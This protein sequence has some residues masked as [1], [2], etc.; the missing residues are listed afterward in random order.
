MKYE[1]NK[2]NREKDGNREQ[3]EKEIKEII[4]DILYVSI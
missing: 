2:G 3:R 1:S 4:A